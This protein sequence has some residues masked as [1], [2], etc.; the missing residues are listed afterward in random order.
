MKDDSNKIRYKVKLENSNT[1][2]SSKTSRTERNKIKRIKS[3]GLLKKT[4]LMFARHS[5]VYQ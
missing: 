5:E 1:N 2:L 3:I 4:R